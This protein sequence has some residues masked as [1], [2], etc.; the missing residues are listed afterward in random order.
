MAAGHHSSGEGGNAPFGGG[1]GGGGAHATPGRGGGGGGGAGMGG[2]IFT[3]RGT[4]T[5]VNDTFTANSASGGSGG[6]G[7][8]GGLPGS[9]LGGAV[10]DY[11]GTV[12]AIFVT[13]SANLAQDGNATPDDGTDVYIINYR[14]ISF[15]EATVTLTNDILGQATASTSDFVA[16]EVSGLT[17]TMS[18]A[19]DLISNNS[20]GTGS[21]FTGSTPITV[22]PILGALGSNGGPTATMALLPGSPA[23]GAGATADYPG[24]STPIT[25][26]QRGIALNSPPDLGAFARVLFVTGLSPTAGPVAGG[27]LVTITG[28]AFTDATEVHFGTVLGTSVDV[29]DDA[30]IVVTSPAQSASTV[31]LTVT[32]P[33]GT[34]PV[35]AGDQF[36]YESQPTSYVV[37]TTDYNPDEAGSL[38]DQIAVATA[39]HD[40]AADITF[41]VPTDSTIQYAPIYALP[42][43]T[44]GPTGY[45][46][47][48]GM[49]GLNI[50]I[51]G[52]GSPGLRLDG[53]GYARLFAV[54]STST[55]TL[56]NLTVDGGLAQGFAGGSADI[57]GGGGGGG[58]G[59][60]G[61]VY[62]D[63]GVFT[64]DGVTFSNNMAQ[65]GT[66]GAG[67]VASENG[68]Q[69]GGGGGGIA[70]S[71]ADATTGGGGTGGAG[72][73]GNGGGNHIAGG[74]GGLGGGGGGGGHKAGGGSGGFGGGGG[75]G[76]NDFSGGNGGFGGGHGGYSQGEG[77]GGAGLGG[78]I[79]SNGGAITLVNDTF[80]ANSAT[81][82]TGGGTYSQDGAAG[83]GS[84]GAV[85]AVNGTLTATFVTFSGNTAENGSGIALDGTDLYV[86]TD[87]N[88]DTGVNGT[89]AS[90]TLIDDILGQSSATTSDF[91][92]NNT[93]GSTPVMNGSHDLIT[94]N[95]PST[96]SGFSGSSVYTVDPLLAPL[97]YYGGPTATMAL[98]DNS[99]ALVKG[100]TAYYDYPGTSDPITTD[101][102]GFPLDSPIDLGA[103]QS[104][105]DL[106]VNTSADTWGHRSLIWSCAR[107]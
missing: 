49:S 73:G 6:S 22:N 39:F 23:L 13:F 31:D 25:A 61:A 97:N 19:N 58:A 54:T 107:R 3:N 41:A 24:T 76:G 99:P 102:R 57:E 48:G 29:I 33:S 10:F 51:D 46:I 65:G 59:L 104:H 106:V 103:Y 79:F 66:G 15:T 12:E 67:G 80:T 5:L 47:A 83:S 60:G 64:A 84:G 26:D 35:A 71:G 63:G 85:F 38:A 9:G 50:T 92:A 82:A 2:G 7:V 70:G 52:S 11:N 18:G 32:T 78:G 96:G 17:P 56:K 8:Y 53:N 91:V 36:T 68:G 74:D 28:S 88:E 94:N 37:T 14:T 101:Q 30:H 4:I 77:G 69:H 62:D 27:T 1:F 90:V 87:A 89:S 43:T 98:H 75:G 72:G 93:G 95:S 16:N 105:A 20:P 40:S 44:Y 100:I 81:G 55:L 42:S 34:S 86:L 21:G 45:L